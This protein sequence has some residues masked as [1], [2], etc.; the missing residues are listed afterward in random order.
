MYV[1]MNLTPKARELKAKINKWDYVKLSSFCTG[2]E[3]AN[4][5]NI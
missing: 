2:K 3:T 4:K 1:I 5:T